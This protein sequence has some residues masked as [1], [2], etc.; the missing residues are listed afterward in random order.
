MCLCFFQNVFLCDVWRFLCSM[1][2]TT[3]TLVMFFYFTPSTFFNPIFPIMDVLKNFFMFHLFFLF[4][5]SLKKNFSFD[6]YR[7][8]PF[9][10]FCKCRNSFFMFHFSW[11]K[12]LCGYNYEINLMSYV[13]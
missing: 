13:V 2:I 3:E 8:L 1:I 7:F 11:C 9:Y 4:F 5:F 12:S 6:V 10:F